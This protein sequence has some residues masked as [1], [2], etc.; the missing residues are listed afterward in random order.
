ML[1]LLLC[2][3]KVFAGEPENRKGQG[4][5]VG[6]SVRTQLAVAAAVA[7]AAAATASVAVIVLLLLLALLYRG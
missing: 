6:F 5:D 1:Y 2:T 3:T 7:A 4:I